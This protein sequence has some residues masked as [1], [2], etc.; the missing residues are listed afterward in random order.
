MS[1][2]LYIIGNGFDLWHGLYTSYKCFNCFMCRQHPEDQKTI[3]RLFN[4]SNPDMLWS[5]F[6]N[7]LGQPDIKALAEYILETPSNG[8]YP[9]TDDIFHSLKTYFQEWV[10][11][12]NMPSQN[13]KRLNLDKNAFFLNFNYTDTLEHC[14]S[15]NSTQIC[16]IHGDTKK[17][18]VAI[19][20]VGH[21]GPGDYVKK[22][23]EAIKKIEPDCDFTT[24]FNEIEGFYDSLAKEPK[25]MSRSSEVDKHGHPDNYYINQYVDFFNRASDCSDIYVLGHSLSVIDQ[26][27]IIR[28]HADSPKA[29]WRI[30]YYNEREKKAKKRNLC[31]LLNVNRWKI[32][33]KLLK[34]DDLCCKE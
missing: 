19:P 6:E 26:P 29:T 16:Y 22:S 23:I 30:S 28:I 33:I 1:K 8:K 15:I 31:K 10:N 24:I 2:K 32:N 7:M 4:P 18:P 13:N 27:Y 5:D 20:V 21:R 17:N 12:I 3:G 14:Y 34:L 9:R 25:I 11:E